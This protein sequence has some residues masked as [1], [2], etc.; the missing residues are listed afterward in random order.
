MPAVELLEYYREALNEVFTEFGQ[1]IQIKRIDTTKSYVD[2]LY[3]E[4]VNPTYIIDE[5]TGELP[6]FIAVVKVSIQP[7]VLDKPI[8]HE[9]V[10]TTVEIPI[11]QEI[12][13]QFFI[14]STDIVMYEGK[15]YRIDAV[16]ED[17]PVQCEDG[18]YGYLVKALLLD[19]R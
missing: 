3:G 7:K 17:R 13:K 18:S 4:V 16:I 10:E 1:P 8:L 5:E 11:Q 6:T 12:D 9:D 19:T 15:D 2:D 14:K